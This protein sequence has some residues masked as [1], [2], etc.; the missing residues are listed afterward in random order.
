VR[1]ALL[2]LIAGMIAPAVLA[3]RIQVYA[4]S[5]AAECAA[6]GERAKAALLKVQGVK[7]VELGVHATEL[8]VAMKEGVNDDAI[9]AGLAKAGLRGVVGSGTRP[10]GY[11]RDADVATLTNDGSRL[12]PLAKLRV[13][14]KYTVF[15]VYADWCGPCKDVDRRLREVLLDR[16]DVAVRKLNV[17]DFDSPLA[18]EL[19]PDFDSLP[20][21]IVFAPA[22]RRT[23]ITGVKLEKLDAVLAR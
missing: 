6:C 11:P 14:D 23:V 13:P 22:G 3:D 20:C 4:L 17:V 2:A 10:E 5:D 1:I 9:L 18:Q 19:G 8:S 21:L 12:G 16:K 7:K 15:D